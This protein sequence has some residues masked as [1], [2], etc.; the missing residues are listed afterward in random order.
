MRKVLLTMLFLSCFSGNAQE[1]DVKAAIMTF[2]DGLQT[3][4]TL[5]INSVISKEMVLHSIAEMPGGGKFSAEKASE[6]T[7]SVLSI[8]AGLK[9]EERIL[10]YDIHIDGSLATAWTPYEF[11]VND[12]LSHRGVNSFQ[13]FKDNGQWKI[14]YIIDTRRK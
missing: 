3:K 14:V 1:S 6:F 2:F 11:Y 13:L 12:K 7:K 8:P 5:K 9:I 10:S 4:D